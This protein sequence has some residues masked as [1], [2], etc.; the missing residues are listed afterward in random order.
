MPSD[1][2]ARRYD[3]HLDDLKIGDRFESGG[4]TL[5]EADIIGFAFKYDPQP[6]HIDVE[7]AKG[8][9]FG[10]LVASG[11]QTLALGFR[12][13]HATGWLTSAN[14]GGVGIDALRWLKP[15]RPG[16]TLRTVTIVK[17]IT[18]SKSKPDR[19]V[20]KHE[21]IVFNQRDEQVMTGTFV[22]VAKRRRDARG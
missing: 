7:A 8:P 10:G 5:T 18:P 21:V 2:D 19:G 9:P 16:D 17:E 13:L 4:Y 1:G 20:L 12:V 14:L 11:F 22:I 15:V 3:V 6:F